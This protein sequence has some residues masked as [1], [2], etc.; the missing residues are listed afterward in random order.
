M[1]VGSDSWAG[2]MSSVSRHPTANPLINVLEGGPDA[3]SMLIF[4]HVVLP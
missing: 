2:P 4:D 3:A 1:I